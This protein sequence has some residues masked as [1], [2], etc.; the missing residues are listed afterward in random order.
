MFNLKGTPMKNKRVLFF[1]KHNACRS[2]IAEALLRR[3]AGDRFDAFSAGLHPR[4]VH[5]LVHTVMEERGIDT[6]GQTSKSID[7]YMGNGMFDHIIIVC[8]ESEADCP[9]LVP[10]ALDVMR[11]P[12]ND[13]ASVS[14]ENREDAL[15]A[16]R[17]VRDELEVK[18][19]KWLRTIE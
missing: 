6:S 2:Q 18:L 8:Q 9:T 12:L 11:W 17:T 3:L 14:S 7:F 1:C 10:M 15:E 16:F 13:P 5:P 4:P 19:T